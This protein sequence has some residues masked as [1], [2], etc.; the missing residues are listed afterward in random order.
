MYNE[1][2]EAGIASLLASRGRNGDS[3][4]V[5]MAPEELSGLQQLAVAHGG[6]LTL[7]PVTGLYEASFLKKLLPAIIGAV[8]PSVPGIGK[9]AGSIGGF[10]GASGAAATTLG[11]G[12]L[13]GGATALIEGD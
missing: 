9:L 3:V 6:S 11:T 2:P 1:A 4:L 8:L 12:L 13:V 10:L 7:N 5:H